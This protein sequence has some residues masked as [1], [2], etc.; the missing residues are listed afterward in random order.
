[1]KQ[2]RITGRDSVYLLS[3]KFE[4]NKREYKSPDYNETE[5]RI[6]FI[7]PFFEALGWDISDSSGRHEVVHEINVD[8]VDRGRIRSKRPDYGFRVQ[9]QTRFFAEAKKP[10]VDLKNKSEPAFQIRRYGW[11]AR[12]PVSV[13]T[14]FE[15]F[16]IYDCRIQPSESYAASKARMRYYTLDQ[17]ADEWDQI[18]DLF[19]YE[20]VQ[21][22]RL[23]LWIQE[24]KPRGTIT[25]DDAFLNEMELWRKLL[26]ED[27]AFQNQDLTRRQLN[28]VVQTTI[29]RIVFLRICE[30]RNI[31]PYGR[32]QDNSRGTHI[33][34]NLLQLFRQA[35]AKYNSGLFH[36]NYET[37]RDEPDNL[38]PH[39]VISDDTLQYIIS[40]LYYPS[41]YAFEVIPA[42]ILGQIYERFLGKVIELSAGGGARIEEKPEVRK[43]G[44]VFYTPTYIVNYIVEN[45]VGKLVGNKTPDEVSGIKILDP[46]CGSGSFLL[47]AFEYLIDWHTK[48]YMSH[49]LTKHVNAKRIRAATS[50]TSEI[51]GGDRFVY[52][53]TTAEKKRILINNLF[54]VDLD[55][56]AVEVTKLSLLLKVL[57]GETSITAQSELISERV[58]PN[59]ENNIRWG[60]SLISPDF[61]IDNKLPLVFEDHEFTSRIK[62]FDWYSP[63]S[64]FGNILSNGGFHAVIGNPPYGANFDKEQADYYKNHFDTSVAYLDTYVLFIE[65]AIQL[66]RDQGLFGMIVPSGWITAPKTKKLREI[67]TKRFAPRVF[68]SLPYDIFKDAY[69]DTVIV[70]GEKFKSG[71]TMHDLNEAPVDIVSF[72]MRYK[73]QSSKDF[74]QFYLKADARQWLNNPNMEFLI[75]KSNEEILLVQKL[76]ARFDMISDI[77]D[78]QRGVTPFNIQIQKPE[79]NPFRAFD[80]TVRRYSLIHKSHSFIRYD[81]TLAEYKPIRYFQGDRILLREIISRQFQIQATYTSEDFITNKSMQSLLLKNHNYHIFYMLGILNSKLMSW[82]FLA[83]SSVGRRDDFPKIV[84]KQTRELPFRAINFNNS[85]DKALYQRIVTL[86]GKMLDYQNQLSGSA[87]INTPTIKSVIEQIDREIDDVVFQLYGLNETEINLIKSAT[88]IQFSKAK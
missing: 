59:L 52:V 10:S 41:P 43:A 3:Q 80:G 20:A 40:R 84:L 85:T 54:G 46:A 37:G 39:I 36:F 66:L 18:Y 51:S 12:L 86:V 2:D 71:V 69:I 75:T 5:L 14:D 19:S 60:N 70:V 74:K 78:I 58:L 47:G 22:N 77:M 13:L 79:I 82:Y 15:E 55:Q 42:D 35:D 11:S 30:D 31:E 53:L 33:Y 56:Q 8:V 17:Y 65:K 50:T 26:A 87:S 1:M 67:F 38:T 27:V 28:M 48:W 32:L 83:T 9:N 6:Q 16:S 81:E 45:T 4:A 63:N 64:G 68:A 88:Q 76:Q 72:P 57:E 29:D 34:A 24:S 61:Y 21:A 73:I 44:G 25:V 62:V 49:D 7:N 23:E